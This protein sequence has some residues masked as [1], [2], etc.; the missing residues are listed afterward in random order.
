LDNRAGDADSWFGLR[1]LD[2]ISANH[3]PGPSQ[4]FIPSQ[5]RS[6]ENSASQQP[7][8]P[9][10]SQTRSQDDQTRDIVII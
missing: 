5:A 7:S 1:N 2:E 3:V 9:H 10:T 4:A 8:G 6:Q